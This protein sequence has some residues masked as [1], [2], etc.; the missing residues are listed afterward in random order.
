MPRKIFSISLLMM[1][2]LCLTFGSKPS[3]RKENPEE[4][5]QE[6]AHTQ[7]QAIDLSGRYRGE[8]H[9]TEAGFSGPATLIINGNK[10][11][12]KGDGLNLSGTLVATRSNGS[13]LITMTIDPASTANAADPKKVLSLIL[14]LKGAVGR[15]SIDIQS[16]TD[17]GSFFFSSMLATSSGPDGPVTTNSNSATNSNTV[18]TNTNTVTTNSNVRRDR[19]SRNPRMKIRATAAGADNS[20]SNANI[21]EPAEPSLF[22]QLRD[23]AH[24]VFTSP[25]SMRFEETTDIELLISPTKSVEELESELTERGQSRSAS[26]QYSNMME[27]QLVGDGFNITPLGPSIQPVEAGKTTRWKWQIK[28]KE[29]GTQQLKLTLNAVLNDGKQRIFLQTLKREITVNVKLSQRAAGWLSTL[30][31]M[32]WLWAA[33]IVPIGTFFIAWWRRKKRRPSTRKKKVT[34]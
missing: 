27:A 8:L 1:G 25:S 22:S 18:A 11:T 26:T 21:K 7:A 33:I 5:F 15:Q 2:F 23:D 30:K 24:A 28:P 13:V 32:H 14:S 16:V 29:G 31:D 3:I 20:S 4:S 6:E 9:Y 12:L 17:R 34:Q 10:F 19:R